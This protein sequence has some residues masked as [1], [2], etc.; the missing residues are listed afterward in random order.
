MRAQLTV[1]ARTGSP[2]THELAPNQSV[3]L[4]RNRGNTIVLH[5]RHSSRWHAEIFCEAGRWYVRDCDTLNGTRLNG[6]RILQPTALADRDVIRIGDTSVRVELDGP[7]AGTA[8]EMPMLPVPGANDAAVAPAEGESTWHTNELN[9]LCEFMA[10]CVEESA[11]RLLIERALQTLQQQTHA[12][13]AGF[14]SLDPDNPLPKLVVPELAAVDVH[15]SRELTQRVQ[16]DR[17]TV[18]LGD[19]GAEP[20]RSDSLLVY[21]D[22]LCVPLWAGDLALGA[23]H[24]YKSGRSFSEREVRFCEVLAGYL[25]RSLH[26]LRLR[27]N[28]EAENSRLRVHVPAIEDVLVGDS[29]TMQQVRQHVERLAPRANTVLIIGESGV[30]K[31]L[32]A[33]SLHRLSARA[34]LPLVTVNCAAI[35]STLSEGELFGHRRGSFTGADRDHSGYFQQAD[36]GTLFL[37]EIGDLSGECQAK[38][39]RVIETK[40][41]R[42]VGAEVE[43]RADVRIIAATHRDL[44]VLVRQGRFRQDLY[45]RLG[46]PVRVP[47]LRDH[48]EDIPALVD[49]FMPRLCQEYRR[50]ARLTPAALRRLQEYSWPGNVRQLRLVL[51]NAMVMGDGE[52]I[53]VSELYL[54]PE[55]ANSSSGRPGLNLEELETWAIRQALQQT[56][57]NVSQ[58]AE[59]LGIHRD[60]LAAKMKKYDIKRNGG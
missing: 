42:P 6:Q 47:P 39:L 22:A 21:R 55:E 44:E 18:W 46:I 8:P 50:P 23:L 17:R 3:T 32:V 43:M 28:L 33:L 16:Q 40:C 26:L 60:T 19:N 27:R 51:E 7:E 37:D 54:P 45:F 49:H 31:E 12:T 38:L 10:S 58:A 13:V 20:A 1:E 36:E 4:G 52:K 34:D 41:F 57:S 48:A 14:L 56:N 9:G 29:P 53:D 59:L 2:T 5:D 25:A 11:P 30:G 15:L 24:V 35:T